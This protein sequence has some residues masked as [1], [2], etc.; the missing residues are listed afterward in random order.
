MAA[1]F[2]LPTFQDATGSAK[3]E[4]LAGMLSSDDELA[5]RNEAMGWLAVRTNDGA[6]AI[7]R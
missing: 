6:D 2:D 7:S 3:R 1:V 4:K 5:L